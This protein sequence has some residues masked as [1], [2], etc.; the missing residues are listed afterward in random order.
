MRQSE[1]RSGAE[2]RN[3]EPT[4]SAAHRHIT[5]V[6]GV[7]AQAGGSDGKR[8]GQG[9]RKERGG[10]IDKNDSLRHTYKKYNNTISR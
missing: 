10:N 5:R 3:A 9:R 6:C 2:R 8:R 4:A 7:C 1:K